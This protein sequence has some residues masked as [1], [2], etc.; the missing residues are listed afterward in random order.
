LMLACWSFPCASSVQSAA[1]AHGLILLWNT[2]RSAISSGDGLIITGT[3]SNSFPFL[4]R[5]NQQQVSP[6]FGFLWFFAAFWVVLIPGLSQISHH[7]WRCLWTSCHRSRCHFHS[8]RQVQVLV[9]LSH[10][11]AIDSVEQQTGI[12]LLQGQLQWSAQNALFFHCQSEREKHW[13]SLPK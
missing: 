1:F 13:L 8:K 4:V 6:L 2:V 3:V 9:S 7:F 12:V 11:I 5:K 10:L